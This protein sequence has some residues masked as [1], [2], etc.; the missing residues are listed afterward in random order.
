MINTPWTIYEQNKKTQWSDQWE[1]I[2]YKNEENFLL[3]NS[4]S[5]VDTLVIPQSRITK[6][7]FP[8]PFPEF[9]LKPL[10]NKMNVYNS[11]EF[12]ERDVTFSFIEDNSFSWYE[13]FSKW[14]SSIYNIERK[15]FTTDAETVY[16]YGSVVFKKKGLLLNNQTSIRFDFERL[17]LKSFTKNI[18]LTYDD[19]KPLEFTVTMTVENVTTYNPNIKLI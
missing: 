1:F 7:D 15:Q 11:A 10:P 19:G 16:R 13:Y 9:K 12:D 5:T 4:G 3:R 8:T 14:F 6:I 2:L 18:N 17:K